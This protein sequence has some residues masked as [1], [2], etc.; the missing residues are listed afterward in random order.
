MY[1]IKF[2]DKKYN[3]WT[4]ITAGS[5]MV[6]CTKHNFFLNSYCFKSKNKA[7]SHIRKILHSKY[8]RNGYKY[9]NFEIL[10]VAISPDYKFIP[11]GEDY[12]MVVKDGK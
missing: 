1:I 4:Y 6:G 7:K 9:S 8:I 11:K 2:T 10:P 12:F 3:D 5:T